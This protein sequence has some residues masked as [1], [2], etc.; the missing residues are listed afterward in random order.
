MSGSPGRNP[1]TRPTGYGKPLGCPKCCEK[2]ETFYG[3]LKLPGEKDTPC[4]NCGSKLT[5][6]PDLRR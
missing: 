2:D 6:R 1:R 3:K 4:P 5:A